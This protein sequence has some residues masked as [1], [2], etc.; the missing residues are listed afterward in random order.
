MSLN[1]YFNTKYSTICIFKILNITLL[2]IGI[3][4]LFAVYSITIYT[5]ILKLPTLFTMNWQI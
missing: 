4:K 3:T 2:I 1:N 5:R